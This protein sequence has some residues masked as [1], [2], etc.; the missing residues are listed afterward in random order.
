M[1]FQNASLLFVRS[2]YMEN[3]AILLISPGLN[4][5]SECSK[6]TQIALNSLAFFA[7]I[8]K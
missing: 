4:S 5:I 8:I 2:K 7:R 3:H 1:I 6:F